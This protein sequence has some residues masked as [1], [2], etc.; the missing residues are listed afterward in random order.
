MLLRLYV[1]SHAYIIMFCA[2]H[3]TLYCATVAGTAVVI[4]ADRGACIVDTVE[5]SRSK[6]IAE[7]V[8]VLKL[9]TDTYGLKNVRH[10]ITISKKEWMKKNKHDF[11]PK[12]TDNT[13]HGM[14][15]VY[16]VCFWNLLF[17]CNGFS[18]VCC[19]DDN[20]S[21]NRKTFSSAI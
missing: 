16:F 1:C 9:Q 8:V 7:L 12:S 6:F 20:G 5:Q 13:M 21:G 11:L 18:L 19:D 17:C 4:V 10:S 14:L 2:Y 3:H 15:N